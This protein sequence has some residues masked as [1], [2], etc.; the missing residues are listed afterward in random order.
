MGTSDDDVQK[1]HDV[2]YTSHPILQKCA[3]GCYAAVQ[4]TADC[5]QKAFGFTPGCSL[6]FGSMADCSGKQCGVGHGMPCLTD[7]ESE[8]CLDCVETYCTDAL[9][10]CTGMPRPAM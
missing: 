1:L 6:C 3:T 7:K 5:V 8:A 4:C 9:L 10:V 2:Q